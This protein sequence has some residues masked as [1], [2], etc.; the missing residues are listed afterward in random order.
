M[1]QF[2]VPSTSPA[3]ASPV[4]SGRS[5]LHIG[6]IALACLITFAPILSNGFVSW[7]DYQTISRNPR[8]NPPS[9]EGLIYYWQHPH[10]HL[11]APLTY[12][13]WT[14]LAAIADAGDQAGPI[15]A[16]L[17]H[18]ASLLFHILTSLVVFALL[19]RLV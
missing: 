11:Y 5:L 7:D 10:M 18:A 15:S 19:R 17:F 2:K 4:T 6:L 12:T 3:S 13:V 8:L 16:G 1:S 9:L 14:M